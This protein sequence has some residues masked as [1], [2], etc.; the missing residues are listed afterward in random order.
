MPDV[1]VIGSVFYASCSL[2]QSSQQTP[3]LS[4]GSVLTSYTSLTASVL[5]ANGPS[6]VL[7]NSN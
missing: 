4:C 5:P 6:R 7:L 2:Q 1:R 3:V